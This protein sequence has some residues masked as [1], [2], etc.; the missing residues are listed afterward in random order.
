MSGTGSG[1]VTVTVTHQ[2]IRGRAS[3][4]SVSA[5]GLLSAASRRRGYLGG[6]IVGTATPGRDWQVFY[7]FDCERSVVDWER[8]SSHARWIE[9]VER[10]ATR[11]DVHRTVGEEL[12]SEPAHAET[13]EPA[14]PK[15][16]PKWKMALVTLTAVF[17]P[18]LLFNVTFI[19]YLRDLPVV[20]RTFA[21]CVPVTAIVTWVMMPRLTRLLKSWLYPV[22]RREPPPAPPPPQ[23][24]SADWEPAQWESE[25]QEMVAREPGWDQRQ[26]F[27]DPETPRSYGD[28][29]ARAREENR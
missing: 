23:R 19:P 26:L 24:R 4:F 8:S 3:R 5:K 12:W 7:R 2:V 20:L 1:P 25:F 29:L 9:Y 16:P 6:G 28:P 11:T 27:G 22:A 10:F 17:P 21:L 14:P 18:V 15:V 13:V